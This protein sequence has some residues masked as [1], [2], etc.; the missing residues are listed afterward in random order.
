MAF[1]FRDFYR[2]YSKK[3][4]INVLLNVVRSDEANTSPRYYVFMNEEGSYVIQRVVITA[5]VGVYTYYGANKPDNLAT[6]W[7]GRAGLTYVEF[8]QLFM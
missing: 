8:Y 5:G 2:G 1:Q 3:G 7:A 6:D 4:D